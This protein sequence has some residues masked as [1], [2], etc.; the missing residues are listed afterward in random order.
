MNREGGR[1]GWMILMMIDDDTAM[2]MM[3]RTFQS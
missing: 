2:M 1:E 3:T